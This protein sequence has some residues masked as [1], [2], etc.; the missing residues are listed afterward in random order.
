MVYSPA[1]E[2]VKEV[3]IS[4]PDHFLN[5]S[6][7]HFVIM[8]NHIHGI[9]N[10][11]G[12]RHEVSSIRRQAVSLPVIEQF[13]KPISGSISTIIRSFKSEV[14]RRVNKI[15]K[16][17]GNKLWQNNYY[18]HVFRNDEEYEAI[19]EYMFTNPQNWEE[20]RLCKLSKDIS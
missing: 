3:W 13:G 6:V 16:T 12:T 7:E 8:P 5:T 19:Y 4:I 17:P 14:T 11:V 1:G 9:I 10:I 20:D 2:I 15:Q 18:E